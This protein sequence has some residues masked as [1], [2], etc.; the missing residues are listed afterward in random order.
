MNNLL[1]S[2]ELLEP[3]QNE[4]A[5]VNVLK[6]AGV[7]V[8]VRHS[9]WYVRCALD[10]AALASEL[11]AVL[12]AYDNVIVVDATNDRAAWINLD[13]KVADKLLR[14]WKRREL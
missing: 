13:S 1:V 2:F 12:D 6:K 5:L 8:R 14:V 7:G 4:A 3:S 9:T 11:R 10:A